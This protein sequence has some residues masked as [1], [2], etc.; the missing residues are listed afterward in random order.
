MAK[1][2]PFK[3]AKGHKR[4]MPPKFEPP[5]LEFKP[6]PEVLKWVE[7]TIFDKDGQLFNEA[8]DHL[9][10]ISLQFLWASQAFSKR[11]RM[12]VGTAEQVAFRSTPWQN[13]RQE[14]QMREWFGHTP[15]YL[16]TLAA[17]YCNE[18]SDIDWCALV[19]HELSHIS[20]VPDAFGAPAFDRSGNPKVALR[21][22]DV[23][24]F[25]GVVERYGVGSPDSS[26]ARLVAAANR[27]PIFS[28]AHIAA[29]C[30]TCMRQSA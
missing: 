25:I 17:D 26:V 21:G 12:V 11:G 6:A 18:C 4:P 27:K 20:H 23:E 10:G 8:H 1:I 5:Y 24:E 2:L 9:T 15:D 13:G 28:G 22:H 30:G 3:L 16:I 14:V 29:A 19:E 7:R